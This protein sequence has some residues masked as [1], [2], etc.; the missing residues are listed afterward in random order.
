M[1]T[2]E[3][4]PNDPLPRVQLPK[5]RLW[6]RAFR[7][8]AQVGALELVDEPD[9]DA[10][11]REARG[12]SQLESGDGVR[13][14]AGDVHSRRLLLLEAEAAPVTVAWRWA[15]KDCRTAFSWMGAVPRDLRAVAH[16]LRSDH[17]LE[18]MANT[19]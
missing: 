1:G 3:S 13:G 11:A 16:P 4:L 6:L 5:R 18:R 8:L 14:A 15:A 19:R 17:Q 12:L 10:A 7:W 2:P 9:D